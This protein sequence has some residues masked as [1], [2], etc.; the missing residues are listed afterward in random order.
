MPISE[1]QLEEDVL[2]KLEGQKFSRREDIRDRAALEANFRQKFEVI[3]ELRTNTAY[4]SH[5]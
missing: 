1:L 5:Q 4:D 3:N 2:K